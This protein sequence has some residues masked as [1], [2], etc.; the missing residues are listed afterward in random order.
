MANLESISIMVEIN[1]PALNQVCEMLSAI[2]SHH[3]KEVII[4]LGT[5]C[6]PDF[7][8][9]VPIFDAEEINPCDLFVMDM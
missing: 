3:L 9:S 5:N 2:P 7:I 1:E 4:E 8:Y 6:D